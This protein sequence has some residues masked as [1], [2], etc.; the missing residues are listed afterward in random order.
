MKGDM[1]S[2]I[3]INDKTIECYDFTVKIHRMNTDTVFPTKATDNDLGLDLYADEVVLFRPGDIKL[4]STG[5]RFE[6]PERWGG[7]LKDRSSVASKKHLFVHAGVIDP[8][9]RGEVK[10]LFHN[11]GR[12]NRILYRGDKITQLVFTYSP[13]VFLVEDTELNETDRGDKGFGS[14]GN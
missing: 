7:L 3:I 13:K 6:F 1:K 11:A 14:S 10:V 9:Y 5:I 12:E 8:G 4:V 2:D